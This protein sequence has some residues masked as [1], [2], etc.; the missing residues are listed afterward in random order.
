[1]PA[2]VVAKDLAVFSL[3]HRQEAE[4]QEVGP[5]CGPALMML[6]SIPHDVK[7]MVN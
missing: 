3:L 5:G 4:G 2:F 7:E 1:M 6:H